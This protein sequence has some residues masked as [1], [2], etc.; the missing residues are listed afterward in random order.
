MWVKCGDKLKI[1]LGILPLKA[2][3]EVATNIKDLSFQARTL[4]NEMVSS[5]IQYC[6]VFDFC[7]NQIHR[8]YSITSRCRARGVPWNPPLKIFC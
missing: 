8:S 5:Y 4:N 1:I 7:M 6:D 2:M 3:L